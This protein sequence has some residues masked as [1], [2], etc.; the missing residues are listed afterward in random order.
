MGGN[1]N[2]V[3]ILL[4]VAIV[5]SLATII[6][7]LSSP[8]TDGFTDGTQAQNIVVSGSSSGNVG[9]EILPT[10]GETG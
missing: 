8:D 5:F 2:L 4:I 9:I 10:P 1:Q 7:S 3:M 6:L